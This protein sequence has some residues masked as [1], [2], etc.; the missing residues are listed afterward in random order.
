M[1]KE[2]PCWKGS[3]T[4]KQ[5]HFSEIEPKIIGSKW[6]QVEEPLNI[7]FLLWKGCLSWR[8]IDTMCDPRRP[9]ISIYFLKKNSALEQKKR[10][11]AL[12][13]LQCVSVCEFLRV[14][15]VCVRFPPAAHNSYERHILQ[16]IHTSSVCVHKS[17]HFGISN[18]F[19]F[20]FIYFKCC[21][22][23]LLESRTRCIN[24]SPAINEAFL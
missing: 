3:R 16:S 19:K 6:L 18:I 15:A 20:G 17:K 2:N 8:L 5:P 23:V 24:C 14:P 21:C 4:T 9:K 22:W 13:G 7:F 11:N 1:H 10:N 12:L